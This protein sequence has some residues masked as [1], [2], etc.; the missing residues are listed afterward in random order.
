MDNINAVFKKYIRP[1]PNPSALSMA[2]VGLSTLML[3]Y[4]VAYKE[5]PIEGY[6]KK[7]T[8]TKKPSDENYRIFVSASL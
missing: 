5:E 3:V 8:K 4:F 1:T 2:M 6:T 7:K